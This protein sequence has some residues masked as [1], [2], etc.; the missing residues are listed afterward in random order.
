M[1]SKDYVIQAREFVSL[2]PATT[3]PEEPYADDRQQ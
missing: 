1:L 2:A 3:E